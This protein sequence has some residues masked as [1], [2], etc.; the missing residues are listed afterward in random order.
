MSRYVPA[1]GGGGGGG[2]GK[3]GGGLHWLVHNQSAGCSMH[4]V[5][6]LLDSSCIFIGSE[7][8]F[9]VIIFIKPYKNF[10]SFSR[11]FLSFIEI[12]F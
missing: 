11:S 5:P 7:I 6:S 2:G 12:N 8:W 9:E 4:F 10:I 1:E 3:G